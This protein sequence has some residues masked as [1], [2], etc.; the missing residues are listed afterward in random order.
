VK[1]PKAGAPKGRRDQEHDRFSLIYSLSG[2][3]LDVD[4]LL[5]KAPPVARFRSWRKGTANAVGVKAKTSGL[6]IFLY[7]GSSQR[8]LEN[9]IRGFLRENVR[10]L[11]AVAS[12]PGDVD[13]SM[14]HVG[15]FVH[16]AEPVSVSMSAS[17]LHEVAQ[18]GVTWRVT[19][20]PCSD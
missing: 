6:R 12:L 15:L 11:R 17:L 8:V 4:Q 13:D 20:Y 7:D 2:K 3:R 19:G 16:A 9:R 18:S 5:S 10:F 14:L 1:K